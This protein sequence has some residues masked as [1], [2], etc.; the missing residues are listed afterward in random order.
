MQIGSNDD[1]TWI[2]EQLIDVARSYAYDEGPSTFGGCCYSRVYYRSAKTA[3]PHIALFIFVRWESQSTPDLVDHAHSSRA[4]PHF[5]L[6]HYLDSAHF[7]LPIGMRNGFPGRLLEQQESIFVRM[8]KT[9]KTHKQTINADSAVAD[10]LCWLFQ[11]SCCPH[12]EAPV[13]E[14]LHWVW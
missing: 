14:T 13:P 12:L 1:C 9:L 10:T 2:T 8:A 4:F 3:F 7:E 6:P 11:A 5:P